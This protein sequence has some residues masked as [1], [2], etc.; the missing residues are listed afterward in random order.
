MTD[1]W[2]YYTVLAIELVVIISALIAA[3]VLLAGTPFL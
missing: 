3:V 2:L 1:D